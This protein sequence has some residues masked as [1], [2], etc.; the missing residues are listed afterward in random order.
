MSSKF[1]RKAWKGTK[2]ETVKE[3][4]EEIKSSGGE[5][6][7]PNL[8]I[9]EGTN[10]FRMFPAHPGTDEKNRYSQAN[11]ISWVPF[12]KDDGKET[13][14]PI[15]NARIHGGQ[16]ADVIETYRKIA[17]EII[18]GDGTL[19]A[20]D[21]ASLIDI[22]TD[23]KTGISPKTS[24]VAYAKKKDGDNWVRGLFEYTYGVHKDLL[25]ES[26]VDF[27]EEPDGADVVS[28]PDE[29]CIVTIKYSPKEKNPNDKYKT[30]IGAKSTL[31]LE[32][33]DFEWLEEQK[34]LTELLFGEG[35]YH[36]GTFDRAMKG[37]QL[38]DEKHEIGVFDEDEFQEAAAE[39]RA[40]LP[41]APSRDSDSSSDDSS[42]EKS[43]EDMSRK[44]L[45]QYILDNNLDVKVT[46]G[47]KDDEIIDAIDD[48]I[49][50]SAGNQEEE[51][52]K[53]F[54]KGEEVDDQEAEEEEPAG[55]KEEESP[56]RS[57][58]ERGERRRARSK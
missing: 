58:R 20:K 23:W 52:D 54:E 30:S 24:Y 56:R 19:S 45:K 16:E 28:D 15:K 2:L 6:K 13:R 42:D 8:K 53:P 21:K 35:V 26:L 36:Q 49:A 27:D 38:Y 1:D 22:M 40:L 14:I 32:D 57:R 7:V 51:S 34:P 33:E 44:E 9:E 47:M 48:A 17:V 18:K 55:E 43:L 37:L 11:T 39:L 41:E 12:V 29:G 31:A 4:S 10:R 25:D 46:R 5:G 3:Q 50:D